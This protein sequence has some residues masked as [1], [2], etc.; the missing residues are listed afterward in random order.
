MPLSTVEEAYD[1]IQYVDVTLECDDIHL[2]TSDPFSLLSWLGSPPS[3]FYYLIHT[4]PSD[5]SI[6]EAIILE[7]ILWKDHHHRSSFLLDL[8]TVKNNIKSLVSPDVVD[9]PQILIL[10]ENVLSE[11]NLGYI[12][13]TMFIG[14]SVKPGVVENI[15]L[16]QTCSLA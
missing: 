8:T 16:G 13:L 10:M 15:Q 3:Y 11:G 12:T 9:N 7:E 1:A 14:I 2:V 5:E 4:F 6:M